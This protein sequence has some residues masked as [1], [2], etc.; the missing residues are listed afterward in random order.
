LLHDLCKGIPEPPPDNGRPRL[1]LADAVFSAAFKV[2]STF[3]QVGD[4]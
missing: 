4:L 3:S 2:H 1:S